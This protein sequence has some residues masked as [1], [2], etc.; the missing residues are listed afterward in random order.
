VETVLGLSMTSS[1]VGWVVLDGSGVDAKTLDHDVVDVSGRSA[2][3]IDRHLGAV[4]GARAIAAASGQDVRSIGVGWTDESAAT[5][6]LVL[7]ALPGLGFDKVVPVRLAG[8]GDD[9]ELTARAAAL[10]VTSEI[11]AIPVPLLRR[12]PVAGAPPPEYSWLASARAAA[13]LVAGLSA[14]FVLAP[15]LAGQ[16]AAAA[17]KVQATSDSP[18]G[19]ES[20]HVPAVPAP[21]AAPTPAVTVQ[22]VAGRPAPRRPAAQPSVQENAPI[23]TY[24]IEETN[25]AGAAVVVPETP[26]S[27]Q[28]VGVPHLPVQ[29]VSAPAP[30]VEPAPAIPSP[31]PAQIVFSP[32][33]SALP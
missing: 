23:T 32:L 24:V 9:I 13:V 6:T 28:P 10:A 15:E 11:D 4:R 2:D 25:P 3:D 33:F 7:R 22:L 12:E 19:W 27:A 20:V 17:P 21:D 18:S 14:L 5:A 16:P 8:S 26:T 30:A 1:G 31:D 29:Q